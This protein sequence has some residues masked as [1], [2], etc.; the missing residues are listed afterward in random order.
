MFWFLGVCVSVC[1]VY[2][3]IY[4][5]K[6]RIEFFK[7]VIKYLFAFILII[8]IIMS[9]ICLIFIFVNKNILVNRQKLT[10]NSCGDCLLASFPKFTVNLYDLTKYS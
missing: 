6:I 3:F 4:S 9:L 1:C 5:C 8:D 2:I 7:R 10:N